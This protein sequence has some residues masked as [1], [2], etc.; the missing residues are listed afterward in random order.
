MKLQNINIFRNLIKNEI[1]KLALIG[2]PH[3]LYYVVNVVVI[4]SRF[5]LC[6]LHR[7]ILVVIVSI[8]L[9]SILF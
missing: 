9:L 7:S 8:S 4:E 3:T 6:L 1:L 2:T 5:S